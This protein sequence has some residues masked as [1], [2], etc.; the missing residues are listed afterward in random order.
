MR[1]FRGSAAIPRKR[2][3]V[4]VSA[5]YP[6][7]LGGQEV[8]VQQLA[9][10]LSTLGE[11][12]EVVTSHLGAEPG[13][14][15][16][17]GVRV[18]R[19]RSSELGH[20]AVIWGLLWWLVKRTSRDTAVH[21]HV[22]QAFTPEVVWFASKLRRFNYI[23]HMHIDPVPSGALAILLPLYKRLVLGRAI[24]SAATVIVLNSNHGD[25]IKHEY[26]YRG[27]TLLMSNGV[28][29]EFFS[30]ARRPTAE[31]PVKLLFVGRLSPQKNL[32]A[33]LEAIAVSKQD[34][35][36]DIVGEGECRNEIERVIRKRRLTNVTLYGRLDRDLVREHY[37][38]CSAFILPSLY[39]AQPVALL[40]AMASRI[41]IIATRVVGIEPVV[42]GGAAIF[43][44]PTAEGL[45][46]GI[47]AFANMSVECRDEMIRAA[48]SRAQ[49]F[50]WSSLVQS[51]ISLYG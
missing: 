38:T 31:R 25:I 9:A 27:K 10:Q 4:H 16:E 30:L 48:F 45:A 21:V 11:H 24:K 33:L 5:Y 42:A 8:V 35:T 39:E 47:A 28:E 40:E 37:A 12:V 46:Q 29:Q 41:P 26:G 43:V 32:T 15:L 2:S 17:N 50:S 22:G 1:R 49:G 7:H 14:A 36:L 13:V 3:I 51:Y 18:S 44:E 6:P 20:A 34:V 19:L 23:M